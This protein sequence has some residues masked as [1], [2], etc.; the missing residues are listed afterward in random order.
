MLPVISEA[1]LSAPGMNAVRYTSYPS[2]PAVKDPV[3]IYCNS[4]GTEKGTLSALRPGGSGVYDYSWFSWN[5]TKKSFIDSLKTDVGVTSSSIF[6][7]NEGGYKVD[8]YSAGIYDTS[9]VGWIFFDKPP[10]VKAS[11]KQQLCNRVALKGDT[12]FSINGFYYRDQVTGLPV[13]LPNEKTFMWSSDPYSIIPYPDAEIDPITYSPPLE[14]VTYK[15]KVNNLG[16]SNESSFPYE[17]IHV[18]A[19]FSVDPDKGE[20]PLEVV[21]T[22]K[23]IRGF[24][25]KWEFGD[26]KDSISELKNPEPH[27]Y[28]KPGEYSVKL[29]IESE[30]QHCIDSMR[31]DKIVVDPSKLEIPNVFTPDGD[32]LN[33]NF[34]V[35]SKSLRLISVEVFSRSG[36]KV[37]S[38]YG[39]GENLR[40]WKGWDGN[41][42]ASSIKASPGVYFYIIRAYGW[43][44]VDYN[45][46]D[47]RGFVYLYR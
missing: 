27:I 2:A 32:G 22:D 29:T 3:F 45:S 13:K 31:F 1:Q 25:Y 9:L 35:E 21:F 41:I 7:L 20:A 16:C 6:N 44:D 17:S 38:F 14:N 26:G 47:Y 40:E 12:S 11:L 18:K 37:Y 46:K 30:L 33:D 4:T 36:M 28:Y 15:L 39:E 8:I 43:D 34:M 19:D 10:I 23:S 24:K 42:N 5:D